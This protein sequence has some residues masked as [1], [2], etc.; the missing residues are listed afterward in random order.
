MFES[1]AGVFLVAGLIFFDYN[2]YRTHVGDRG[3]GVMK[4]RV[5]GVVDL[6]GARKPSWKILRNEAS[7]VESMR[8]SGN[9]AALHIELRTRSEAP[10]YPLHNYEIRAVAYGFGNIPVE[11]I[12]IPVEALAPGA[13]QNVQLNFRQTGISRIQVDLLRPTGFSAFTAVWTP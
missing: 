10:S 12:G 4:Q 7:P 13:S 5:H 2:D 6:Y 11:R 9:P 8:V 1:K 3:T